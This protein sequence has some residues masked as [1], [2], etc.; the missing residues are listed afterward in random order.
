M[1]THSRDDHGG[2]VE[3]GNALL[4][5]RA[6]VPAGD[7]IDAAGE[8]TGLEDTEQDTANKQL[9]PVG[10]ESH[11][12]HDATPQ[13]G[14]QGQPDAATD[15]TKGHVGR[16]LKDDVWR[17]EDGGDDTV[18]LSDG[19]LEILAHTGDASNRDVCKMEG[20]GQ[21]LGMFVAIS[22]LT[23]TIDERDGIDSA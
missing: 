5:L 13:D 15:F 19:E 14:D 16:E 2:E 20:E 3:R 6:S 9:M 17:E 4:N 18:T 11:S 23:G 1:T 12:E 21:L 10:K 7:E 22:L 8:E